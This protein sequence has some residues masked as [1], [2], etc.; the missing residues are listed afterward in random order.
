[1]EIKLVVTDL[2]EKVTHKITVKKEKTNIDAK[3]KVYI[4]A[5]KKGSLT[6]TLKSKHNA[7]L[8]NK[9]V[10]FTYNNKTVTSKTNAN[11]KATITIPVLAEGTYKIKYSYKG[12][13]NYYPIQVVRS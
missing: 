5:K 6:V 11:G 8:K 9:K 3:D 10:T 2:D 1:M 13:D 4:H 7:L 12:S